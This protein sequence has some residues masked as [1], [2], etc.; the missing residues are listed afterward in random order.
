M[1]SAGLIK[2][3]PRKQANSISLFTES[4]RPINLDF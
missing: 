3:R 2:T 4:N 1:S